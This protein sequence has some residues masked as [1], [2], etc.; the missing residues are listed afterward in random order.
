LSIR[1]PLFALLDRH[2]QKA[3]AGATPLPGATDLISHL[4]KLAPLAIVTMQGPATS[5]AI[6]GRHRLGELFDVVVTRE[7][8]LDRAQQL[9]IALSTLAK[10]PA[11]TLFTGDRL[12]DIICGKR[13]GVQTAL[14]WKEPTA[15]P[16]PDHH[17][18]TLAAMSEQIL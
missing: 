8:S 11:E 5:D 3:I 7:D 17:F 12:N 4:S 2:E 9:R 10:A 14:V 15:E 6:L 18:P 16:R 1:G 13:A